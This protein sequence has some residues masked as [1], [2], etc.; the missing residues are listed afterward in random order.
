MTHTYIIKM[1]TIC[2]MTFLVY[3]INMEKIR[4]DRDIEI[5]QDHLT[6]SCILTLKISNLDLE[7]Y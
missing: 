7:L 2:N 4:E 3:I 6:W 1:I 5:A